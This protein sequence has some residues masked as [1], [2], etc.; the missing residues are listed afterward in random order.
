MNAIKSDCST[1]K[2]KL[3]KTCAN[4]TNYKLRLMHSREKKNYVAREVLELQLESCLVL[5]RDS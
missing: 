2:M 5:R 1:N 4:Q 3:S